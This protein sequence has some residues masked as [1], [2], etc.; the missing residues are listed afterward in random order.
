MFSPYPGRAYPQ[1]IIGASQTQRK[2]WASPS[3]L[4]GRM[5]EAAGGRCQLPHTSQQALR[6][7]QLSPP[8]PSMGV[9]AHVHMGGDQ[10]DVCSQQGTGRKM[11]VAL[12]VLKTGTVLEWR[13][14]GSGAMPQL[15]PVP[16]RNRCPRG[17]HLWAPTGGRKNQYPQ[18]PGRNQL[19]EDRALLGV[20]PEA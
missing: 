19:R 10:A 13:H 15:G 5:M 4:S 3:V 14:E 9:R 8:Q 11:A 16:A 2:T 1:L 18:S 12:H 7:C 17:A 20:S 6:L